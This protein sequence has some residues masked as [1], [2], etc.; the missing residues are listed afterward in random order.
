MIVKYLKYSI[1][2]PLFEMGLNLNEVMLANTIVSF[3]K[4]DKPVIDSFAGLGKVINSSGKT[5]ERAIKTLKEKE[6]IT[7]LSGFK[8]KNANQYKPTEK[9]LK[10]YRQNVY[11][12]IDK[13]SKNTSSIE[14]YTTERKGDTL[15]VPPSFQKKY[16]FY[17]KEFGK[18]EANKYLKIYL[19][20]VNI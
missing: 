3:Y 18:T 4:E 2:E 15:R 1:Y 12:D 5:A 10:R 11:N 14:E 9:L 16:E 20:K 6:L 8:Q 13:L 19:D 17:V 7:V